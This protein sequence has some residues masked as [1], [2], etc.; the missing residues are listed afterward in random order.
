[1]PI[2]LTGQ[3]SPAFQGGGRPDTSGAT[4]LDQLTFDQ[5]AQIL[6]RA[7]P[8]EAQACADALQNSSQSK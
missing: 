2:A 6:K 5:P 3:G 8:G 1:M 4:V 7:A